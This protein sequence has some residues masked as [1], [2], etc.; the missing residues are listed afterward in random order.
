MMNNDFECVRCHY[1]TNKKSSMNL[2]INKK[3]RCIK[4]TESENIPDDECDRLSLVRV[5][6]RD[7]QESKLKCKYCEK[8]Y[9][10]NYVLNTHIKKY[11]KK[12]VD[13]DIPISDEDEIKDSSKDSSEDSTETSPKMTDQKDDN[14]TNNTFNNVVTNTVTNTINNLNIVLPNIEYQS[15][16]QKEWIINYVHTYV[17]QILSTDPKYTEI[18]KKYNLNVIID[19]SN[20]GMPQEIYQNYKDLSIDSDLENEKAKESK[21]VTEGY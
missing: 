8:I 19:K 7:N 2:H 10:N 13:S 21:K 9:C 5:K 16:E 3:K 12:K 4:L 11:C 14:A 20:I 1:T 15:E 17:K 18:L 6:D